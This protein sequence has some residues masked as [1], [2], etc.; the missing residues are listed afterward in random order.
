M[1][2]SIGQ[3]DEL[4]AWI[5]LIDSNKAPGN[6]QR[7]RPATADAVESHEPGADDRPQRA[8]GSCLLVFRCRLCYGVGPLTHSA[9]NSSAD[10]P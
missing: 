3:A 2:D 8:T 10:L 1:A 7:L 9:F 4:S 5:R 6:A